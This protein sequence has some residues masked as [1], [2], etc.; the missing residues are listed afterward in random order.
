[1][2]YARIPEP[3]DV[4]TCPAGNELYSHLLDFMLKYNLSP[5]GNWSCLSSEFFF[6]I[7][8][9]FFSYFEQRRT[10]DKCSAKFTRSD[11]GIWTGLFLFI[12]TFATPLVFTGN[13]SSTG[14]QLSTC[15]CPFALADVNIRVPRSQVSLSTAG[16]HFSKAS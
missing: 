14:M 7:V 5:K 8:F 9:A 10:R 2:D 3:F 1:M 4:L 11:L 16:L 13:I 6:F 12:A 15:C